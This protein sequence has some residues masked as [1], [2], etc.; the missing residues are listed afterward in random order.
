MF[1]AN[2]KRLK[3]TDFL[4]KRT[5]LFNSLLLVI[6]HLEILGFQPDIWLN[7]RPDICLLISEMTYLATKI[8]I[9]VRMPKTNTFKEI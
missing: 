1:K 7:I 6:L 3:L 8:N 4:Y 2:L 5:Y 9:M